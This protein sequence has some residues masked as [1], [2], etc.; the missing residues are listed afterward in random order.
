VKPPR[1]TYHAPGTVA[2]ALSLLDEHG[3]QGKVLAGGQSLLPV[4]SFRLATPEHLIDINRLPGLDEIT[5]LTSGG[6]RIP[7]LVRQRQAERS[8]RLAA[9]APLLTEALTQVAHPQIR[10]RGTICGSLAHADASAEM[11]AVMLALNA[12]MT[13][14]SA[15]GT[16][17]VGADDFFVFHMTTAIEAN[18]L[19]LSAEFDD[20]APRTYTSFTEFAPRKGDFC[21]AGVAASVTFAGD[22]TVAGSRVVAAGVAATPLR[23]T[24]VEELIIG[25]AL[26]AGVLAAAKQA[27]S[28]TVDPSGDV[29]ADAE[30]RRQLVSVLVARA[31]GTVQEKAVRAGDAGQDGKPGNVKEDGKNGA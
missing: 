19:L 24:A 8:P 3:D 13:I 26:D 1:F 2:E 27:V 18:E 23:L 25:S 28:D 20:P 9:S 30:Y 22:G 7:A 16:R 6:W 10:N 11:P 15:A 4:L 14:A 5:R 21:L 29:H 12:R 31:L 17:V